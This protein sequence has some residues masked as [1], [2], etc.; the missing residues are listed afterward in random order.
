MTIRQP[1]NAEPCDE[2]ACLA[3][4]CPEHPEHCLGDHTYEQHHSPEDHCG[5][6]TCDCPVYAKETQP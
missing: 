2:P 3:E 1:T 5:S 6:S 4:A